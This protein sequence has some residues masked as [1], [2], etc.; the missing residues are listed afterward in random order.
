MTK[1]DREIL[2][3]TLAGYA[4]VN[5][6]TEVER[7]TR[8]KQISNAEARAVFDSLNQDVSEITAAECENLEEFRLEHHLIVRDAMEKMA[9]SMGFEPS[10]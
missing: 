1:I 3:Q 2:I 9:R 5:R 6:I 4:E 7:R 8:L 10:F